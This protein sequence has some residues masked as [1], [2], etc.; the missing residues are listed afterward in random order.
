MLEIIKMF[1]QMGTG[2]YGGKYIAAGG[3]A[4]GNIF[5]IQSVGSTAELGVILGNIEALSGKTIEA[6]D[7]VF[8]EFSSVQA[9][10]AA[11]D[12]FICYYRK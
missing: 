8:G 2:K 9:G 3:I 7:T 11:T 12:K 6:G 5:A 1:A 10:P 4:T